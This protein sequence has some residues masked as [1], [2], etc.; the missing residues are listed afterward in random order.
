M[1]ACEARANRLCAH[2]HD[3]YTKTRETVVVSPASGGGGQIARVP[4]RAARCAGQPV[5][6]KLGWMLESLRARTT[7]AA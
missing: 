1:L 2:V 3:G 4:S 7:K 5:T 6:R